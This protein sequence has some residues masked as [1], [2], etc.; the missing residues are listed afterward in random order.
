MLAT[1]NLGG[2]TSS[3]LERGALLNKGTNNA[4]PIARPTTTEAV[5]SPAPLCLGEFGRVLR[6]RSAGVCARGTEVDIVRG[7]KGAGR[8]LMCVAR[9]CTEVGRD[10]YD[11]LFSGRARSDIN[12]G[13][14]SKVRRAYVPYAVILRLVRLCRIAVGT[15]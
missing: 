11:S 15:G 6:L 4:P 3:L 12:M 5:Q 8:G 2:V 14:R 9:L 13:W 1:S 7:A 10:T